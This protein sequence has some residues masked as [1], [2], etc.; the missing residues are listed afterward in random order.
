MEVYFIGGVNILDQDCAQQTSVL[1]TIDTVMH[2][3]YSRSPPYNWN[4]VES[5]IKHHNPYA[6][7]S[8]NVL[9]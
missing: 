8:K 7:Y 3:I 4:I 5:D 6:F 2:L 1:Y 9:S